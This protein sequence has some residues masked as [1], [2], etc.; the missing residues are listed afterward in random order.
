MFALSCFA[1][2][3]QQFSHRDQNL[4]ELFASLAPRLCV[5]VGSFFDEFCKDNISVPFS[6]EAPNQSSLATTPG[7]NIR[8]DMIELVRR[9]ELTVFPAIFYLPSDDPILIELLN[10]GLRH[11]DNM[12]VNHGLNAV[13]SVRCKL[14]ELV[15]K[16]T[17]MLWSCFC[18]VDQ[19]SHLAEPWGSADTVKAI[20]SVSAEL[21]LPT[22]A[23]MQYIADA[24]IEVAETCAAAGESIT[25][26]M[27]N[28]F[29]S[30]KLSRLLHRR[31]SLGRPSS[32]P[33]SVAGGRYE[34]VRS[35]DLASLLSANLKQG[36]CLCEKKLLE[37]AHLTLHNLHALARVL[38]RK[39]LVYDFDS[40]FYCQLFVV[41]I[42]LLD[43]IK[44]CVLDALANMKKMLKGDS[45]SNS[46]VIVLL[47]A[48]AHAVTLSLVD[49]AVLN[50]GPS[51]KFT[52]SLAVKLDAQLQNAQHVM[53]QWLQDNVA[54]FVPAFFPSLF[55]S[56]HFEFLMTEILPMMQ[57]ESSELVSLFRASYAKAQ[58]H[59]PISSPYFLSRIVLARDDGDSAAAAFRLRP[60]FSFFFSVRLCVRC[61]DAV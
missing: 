17:S 48:A 18:G 34:E 51:R 35:Y 19:P 29:P 58:S 38:V 55:R 43:L 20:R 31:S 7:T 59:V 11:I 54:N 40:S 56:K 32:H 57:R 4:H 52:K 46:N 10:V 6:S 9:F 50:G 21:W 41:D 49:D 45:G 37:S 1:H 13:I 30:A 28:S 39:T 5:K 27:P 36:V 3:L 42:N 25:G 47:A 53:A 16:K 14:P 8:P 22:L 24:L 60:C 15:S 44:S 26:Q 2:T 12:V 23:S 61:C 33:T